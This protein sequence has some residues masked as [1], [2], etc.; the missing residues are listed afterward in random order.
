[1]EFNNNYNNTNTNVIILVVINGKETNFKG[2]VILLK[3]VEYC[4]PFGFVLQYNLQNN[5][6]NNNGKGFVNDIE[7]YNKTKNGKGTVELIRPNDV[8]Y[9]NGFHY[10]IDNQDG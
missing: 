3:D 4:F 10:T 7:T 6:D 2:I 5:G 1:M 9:G 8:F